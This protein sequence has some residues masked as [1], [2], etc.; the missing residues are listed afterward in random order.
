[1]VIAIT[2]SNDQRTLVNT[3]F[4]FLVGANIGTHATFDS[5]GKATRNRYFLAYSVL[6][7][8]EADE[9]LFD[10][11][12]NARTPLITVHDRFVDLKFPLKSLGLDGT[13][14]PDVEV[15]ESNSLPKILPYKVARFSP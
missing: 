15:R 6:V 14:K 7:E 5:S 8:N 4:R 11:T 10:S 3:Q 1:M 12:P 9:Q 13:S 2:T